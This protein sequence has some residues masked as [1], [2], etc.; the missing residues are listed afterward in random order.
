MGNYLFAEK[1]F[2]RIEETLIIPFAICKQSCYKIFKDYTWGKNG[3]FDMKK[4]NAIAFLG[5]N[6]VFEGKLSFH[7]A[8]RIDGHFKGEIY[9]DGTLVVGKRGIVEAN[10]NSGSVVISGEVR[11]SINAGSGI[12]ILADA[13]VYGSVCTPSLVIH[14]GVIFEGNCRM[15]K[16]KG[17]PEKELP[18][19]PRGK[20]G[21][22]KFFPT[23]KKK[24]EEKQEE[25]KKQVLYS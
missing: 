15:D 22:I 2:S 25:I 21:L 8:V 18:E 24:G 5:E 9:S 20:K 19:E 16:K 4:T 3:S 17:A 11:G 13:K 12:E 6:T 14:E 1:T 23:G 7:G 10:I